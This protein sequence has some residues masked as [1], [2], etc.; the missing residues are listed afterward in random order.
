MILILVIFF[1]IKKLPIFKNFENFIHIHITFIF[2][3]YLFTFIYNSFIL[4]NICNVLLGIPFIIT[5]VR[6]FFLLIHWIF[7][8]FFYLYDYFITI[9]FIINYYFFIIFNF[10]IHLYK[11]YKFIHTIIKIFL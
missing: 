8:N 9:K 10:I 3:I 4:I 11:K 2:Y 1:F 6:L 5:F 7:N